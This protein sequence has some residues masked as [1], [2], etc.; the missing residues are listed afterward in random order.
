MNLGNE[1]LNSG[2]VLETGSQLSEAIAPD[3]AGLLYNVHVRR[4]LEANQA[5]PDTLVAAEALVA[6]SKV[7]RHL[8]N[9]RERLCEGVNLS[10]GRFEML[11]ALSRSGS[12]MVL[13][14]LAGLMGVTPRNV[15]G[16]LDNLERDGLARRVSDP[17][18]RRSWRAELT[19]AGREKVLQMRQRMLDL[20]DRLSDQ[21]SEADWKQLRHLCWRLLQISSTTP[22][23]HL[24]PSPLDPAI[25]EEESHAR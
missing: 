20:Q 24:P 13:G 17:E 1:L 4:G 18:D 8:H 2:A 6:L 10:E 21:L 15:T 5:S 19:P 9:K 22:R 25:A 23:G 16:L 7:A 3:E 11:L 14:K 12:G